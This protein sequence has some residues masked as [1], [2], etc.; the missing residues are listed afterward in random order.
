MP[1]FELD[2]LDDEDVDHG[3][4][5]V[6]NVD[7]PNLVN[8]ANPDI[9]DHEEGLEKHPDPPAYL[10]KSEPDTT[11][12]EAQIPT[13][14][15]VS[16]PTRYSQAGMKQKT[17]PAE[18]TATMVNRA[19]HEIE[20][21]SA[22]L[23]QL[24]RAGYL[25]DVKTTSADLSTNLDAIIAL[26]WAAKSGRLR[27][28]NYLL[29]RGVNPSATD[30]EEH[31]HKQAALHYAAI[32]GYS[33]EVDILIERGA[34]VQAL[35]A[36]SRSPLHHAA[37]GGF[38]TISEALLNAGAS[39]DLL[40]L[41]METPLHCAAIKRHVDVVELL[42]DWGADIE[43]LAEDSEGRTPFQRS[44]RTP[45]LPAN[46][47]TKTSRLLKPKKGKSESVDKRYSTFWGI[48]FKARS[49]QSASSVVFQ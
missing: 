2:G 18:S 31:S 24:H 40:T 33:K 21:D 23:K 27:A 7:T 11:L 19:T 16:C 44:L 39:V 4:N 45:E 37:T 42:L 17:V 10:N 8:K 25:L 34:D 49:D 43:L 20:Q 47:T 38:R 22:A 13:S 3:N 32:S 1:A 30:N 6:F 14:K 28:L 9:T 29:D 48:F 35:D 46:Y 5:I 26:H 15:K 41:S 36:E 12:K